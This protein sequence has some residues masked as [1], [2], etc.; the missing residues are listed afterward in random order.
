MLTF[1]VTFRV[2][3]HLSNFMKNIEEKQ[4]KIEEVTD[5]LYYIMLYRT[6]LAIIGN[7]THNVSGDIH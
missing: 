5:N 1:V 6:H 2:H 4:K 7:R 3:S